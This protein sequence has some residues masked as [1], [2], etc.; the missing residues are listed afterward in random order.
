MEKRRKKKERGQE[1]ERDNQKKF[2]ISTKME[3]G[4]EGER[5]TIIN[6]DRI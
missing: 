1:E 6:V 2:K 3:G 5:W 4:G